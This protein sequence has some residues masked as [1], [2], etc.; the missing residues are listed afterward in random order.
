MLV[1]QSQTDKNVIAIETFRAL[2]QALSIQQWIKK[3]PLIMRGSQALYFH[4][5]SEFDDPIRW[6]FKLVW[7][8]QRVT[9][10]Q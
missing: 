5:G 8:T 10:K 1:K 3:K 6:D 2:L 9:L 4:L 7:R